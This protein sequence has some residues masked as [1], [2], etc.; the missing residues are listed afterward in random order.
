MRALW[1]SPDLGEIRKLLTS[2][3]DINDA[4]RGRTPAPLSGRR[5]SRQQQCEQARIELLKRCSSRYDEA[6]PV[7]ER[8]EVG[9]RKALDRVDAMEQ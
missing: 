3:V 2:T 5:T 7:G 4:G 8:G 9:V 1:F 6:E